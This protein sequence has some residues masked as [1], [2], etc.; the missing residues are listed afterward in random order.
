MNP[1][2]PTEPA[3]AELCDEST[4]V[5]AG[6]PLTRGEQTRNLLLFAT[7]TGA[8]YLAA[9]VGYVGLTQA[10]LCDR[11]GAG[12]TVANLPATAYFACT[13]TPVFLAWLVP[14]VARLK[15]T[16]ASCF[17]LDT[18]ALAAVGTTLLSPAPNS[19]KIGM[20]I[21]QA[22]VCGATMP[23]AIALLW[24]AIGRGVSERR[25]GFALGLA[26]GCGPVLAVLGSLGSQLL[27]SG[28]LG[29]LKLPG[30]V[31]PWN[32]ATLFLAAVPVMA[33]AAVLAGC[34]IIPL[35][36]VEVGRQ[37]FLQGV[38]GGIWNFV[39]DRVLLTAALV[40]I[41]LYTENTIASNLNLYTKQALG[42]D[43]DQ[44]VGLQN[45]W[46]FGCKAL[47]GLLLGWLLTRTNPKLGILLTAAIFLSALVWAMF[48][49]GLWYLAAFGLY[50]AGELVGVY[51]PNYMLSAS[52]PT[53]IRRNMALVTLLMA[54]AAPAG[55]VFG[56]ISDQVGR[57]HGPAAG[58]RASFAVCAAVMVA[59]I[60]LAIFRLPARP[61]SSARMIPSSS[62]NSPQKPLS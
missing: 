8:I 56:W 3:L 21:A 26:F 55:A 44:F 39:N 5:A 46:R 1:H 28:S 60:L 48:A 51:A 15:L 62:G 18:A 29:P 49:S 53:D 38:F 37:S 19:V 11:L 7:C 31:F 33:L 52:A 12:A 6:C 24:E 54:P 23:S 10:S 17:A 47:A 22:A 4:E 25:R 20:V 13:V 45:A 36:V 42:A 61:R 9:P 14:E 57:S 43:P 16:L 32:F 59:G 2:Q 58:F 35:P 34:F 50:G 41:L 30:M 40:T 27:L